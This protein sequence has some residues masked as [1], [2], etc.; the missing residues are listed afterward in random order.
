MRTLQ[1]HY[2]PLKLLLW[3]AVI[4]A[5]VGL[6]RYTKL[7]ASALLKPIGSYPLWKD[8]F[9]LTYVE[10]TGAAFGSFKDARW[11]FMVLSSIA[12]VV[13]IIYL[14][15]KFRQTPVFMGIALSLIAAGGIGNMIDRIWVGY[16]VDF[17][18]FTLIDFAV[19]NVADSCIT[20]GASLMILYMLVMEIKQAKSHASSDGVKNSVESKE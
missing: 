10:N 5:A 14:V 1:R 12:V 16:V 11:V 9:H 2:Q 19:F 3:A 20:V 7:L 13:I 17:F 8:V 6:D 18:D 15:I 4:T